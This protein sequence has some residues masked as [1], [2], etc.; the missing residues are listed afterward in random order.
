L[1]RLLGISHQA[2]MQWKRVPAER[3]LAIELLTGVS[4]EI[5]RPDLFIKVAPLA[6]GGHRRVAKKLG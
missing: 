3:L 2:I 5:L 4:R 1:A 6:D